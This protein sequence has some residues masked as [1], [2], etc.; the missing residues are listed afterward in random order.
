MLSLEPCIDVVKFD[1]S[2][3]GDSDPVT[4]RLTEYPNHAA[5]RQKLGRLVSLPMRVSYLELAMDVWGAKDQA[6]QFIADMLINLAA[7]R[8]D[9]PVRAAHKIGQYSS[10]KPVIHTDWLK[11]AEELIAAL[12]AG[13]TVYA[14]NQRA[15]KLHGN[16]VSP[17]S[18]RL[19]WK[20]TD[21][22]EDGLPKPLASHEHR[23][24][25]EV[26]IQD[27]A[28][29]VIGLGRVSDWA[30]WE[31]WQ[32]AFACK[33]FAQR[34][35][36][37]TKQLYRMPSLLCGAKRKEMTPEEARSYRQDMRKKTGKDA[38]P[39]K[40]LTPADTQRNT[41]LR[42]ALKRLGR[43]LHAVGQT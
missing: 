13:A 42:N 24:R 35:P 30:S 17:I 40:H 5:A 7:I 3:I 2:K 12:K 34:L 19:Y 27:E 16:E 31:V 14:G 1:F 41:Q 26:C 10:G 8:A 4:R 15:S 22:M 6:L 37:R 38:K 28:L 36:D 9:T 39:R 20:C 25:F 29:A 23:A 43:S 32:P 21:G 11:S 18:F 33:L